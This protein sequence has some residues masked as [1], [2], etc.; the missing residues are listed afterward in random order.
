MKRT[1]LLAGA[2]VLVLAVLAS[3]ATAAT[4]LRTAH[5]SWFTPK[6]KKQVKKAGKRGKAKPR[7]AAGPGTTDVCPG[8]DPNS[9]T[10]STTVVSAGTCEV[11]PYGCTA[12]FVYTNGSSDFI[13]TA[14][15]CVDKVGQDV[16]MQVNTPGVGASIADIG[17]VSKFVN[18][19]VGNDYSVIAIRS[20]FA[21]DP[22]LPEG[23]PQGIYTGCGPTAVL[24][25]G[26]GYGVAV[27]QGKLEGG[28]ATNWYD[29]GYGWTGVG[30]PGDSG[31]AVVTANGFQ[32]AG[33]FT[34]LIVDL[35]GYPGSDLAGTR[36]TKILAGTGLRLV[37]ADGT[38]SGTATTNCGAQPRA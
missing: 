13:G 35:T 20:G 34:H 14:G 1:A 28:L 11:F 9:P 31:S 5:P 3:S 24:H 32:A 37:N 19:G 15:H 23:G 29:D 21:V 38:T 10:P 7:A 25:Y 36:I 12:N 30:A 2:A 16:Y 33:D 6:F 18:G 27:G 17:T 22:K 26:H 4:T 8:V